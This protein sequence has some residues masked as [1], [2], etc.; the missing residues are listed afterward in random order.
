MLSQLVAKAI[1][2]N[3]RPLVG[4]LYA[5]FTAVVLG[6]AALV[7]MWYDL[8]HAVAD[9]ERVALEAKESAAEGRTEVRTLAGTVAAHSL[10]IAV[11]KSQRARGAAQ[12]EGGR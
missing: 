12:P 10:E 1:A 6:T 7:G 5:V 11:L 9:A 8:K 4:W 3:L 2:S